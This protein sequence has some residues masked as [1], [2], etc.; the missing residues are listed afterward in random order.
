MKFKINLNFE[1]LF[2]V[3][4]P[5]FCHHYF[6]QDCLICGLH[7]GFLNQVL[8]HICLKK[9]NLGRFTISLLLDT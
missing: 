6:V 7:S 4:I 3:Y 2:Q 1:V 8:Q 5:I 9:I